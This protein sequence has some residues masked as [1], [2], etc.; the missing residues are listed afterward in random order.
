MLYCDLL[1]CKPAVAERDLDV[2]NEKHHKDEFKF[3]DRGMTLP[4]P[5]GN[6]H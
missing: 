6:K 1:F 5:A 4:Q 3:M 2:S